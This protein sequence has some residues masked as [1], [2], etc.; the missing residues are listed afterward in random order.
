MFMVVSSGKISFVSFNKL[1]ELP[2]IYII[3]K[4]KELSEY[5]DRWGKFDKIYEDKNPILWRNR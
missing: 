5:L 3:Y 1:R 4:Q 2:R